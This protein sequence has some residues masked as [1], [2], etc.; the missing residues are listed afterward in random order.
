[1]LFAA[2]DKKLKWNPGFYDNQGNIVRKIMIPMV[3]KD[4]T[5]T[6][7]AP[8]DRKPPRAD[9]TDTC[10]TALI[11]EF[12][13]LDQVLFDNQFFVVNSIMKHRDFA[14]IKVEKIY[15]ELFENLYV[16]YYQAPLPN[17]GQYLDNITSF[18]AKAYGKH[19]YDIILKEV[20]SCDWEDPVG[21]NTL[22]L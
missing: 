15:A 14:G 4:Y 5:R 13:Q 10:E 1:M 16:P 2:V 12:E 17:A 11:P 8:G 3:Y 9:G 21:Y 18:D 20:M 19:L 6:L 22:G 7:K